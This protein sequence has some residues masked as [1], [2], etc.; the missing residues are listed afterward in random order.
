MP[1]DALTLVADLVT[2]P[3]LLRP[4]QQLKERLPLS[5]QLTTV[6]MLERILEMPD[7]GNRRLSQ[8]LAA[9]ME[10]CLEGE[11]NS[12]FFPASFLHRLPKEIRVLLT[13]EVRGNLKD[14]AVREE[15]LL[16]HH[17]LSPLAAVTAEVDVELA[18]AVGTLG[19]KAGGKTSGKGAKKKEG[20]FR[21]SSGAGSSGA[22]GGGSGTSGAVGSGR[23][24]RTSSATTTGSMQLKRSTVTPLGSV[25]GWKTSGPEGSCSR[26]ADWH[27]WPPCIIVDKA[28]VQ[29]LVDT[30][31]V[32]SVLP[33]TSTDQ[34]TGP[35][36][37][38]TDKSPIPC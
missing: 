14:L 27:H 17:Q 3:L 33:Y 15:E 5:H 6:Q 35:K 18:E 23:S 31:A 36:I 19:I 26:C 12:V 11:T 32:F 2:Q 24:Y 28:G 25:S 34:Q 16:Q 38:A 22:A 21:G 9:M 13:D 29:F 4:Y 8:L 7:L 37:T 10:L 30:G 1:N 20:S